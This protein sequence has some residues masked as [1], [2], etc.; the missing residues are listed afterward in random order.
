MAVF[1]AKPT[2]F[3]E[4]FLLKIGE[5]EYPKKKINLFVY[6]LVK[7]HEEDVEKF[8]RQ[9]KKVYKSF[10]QIKPDDKVTEIRGKT[11]AL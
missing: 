6:N 10:K 5:L 9:Y 2:P 11:L 7:Y 3:F 8:V 1:V 4:D